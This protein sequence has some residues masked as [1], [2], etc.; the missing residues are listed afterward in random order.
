MSAASILLVEDDDDLREALVGALADERYQVKGVANGSEALETLKTGPRPNL[1]LLDLLMPVMNGW[2]FCE[3]VRQDPQL[4][5]I[6][7]VAMS[8]AASRDPQS[9]YYIDVEAF[10]TKPVHME[11]LLE[12]LRSVLPEDAPSLETR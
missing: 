8:G 1:I 12:T 7:I 6:P 9:P 3:R 11:S 4:S 10:V 2:V 5:K